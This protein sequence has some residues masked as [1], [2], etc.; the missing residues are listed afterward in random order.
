MGVGGLNESVWAIF[1]SFL[2]NAEWRPGKLWENGTDYP[3]N[4]ECC[5]HTETSQPVYC[6][7]HLTGFHMTATPLTVNGGKSSCKTKWDKITGG[8]KCIL[9]KLEM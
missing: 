7:N 1:F 9:S 4:C 5:L 6:A 2:G 3:I 8:K